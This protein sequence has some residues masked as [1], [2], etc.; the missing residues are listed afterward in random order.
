ML[1][2]QRTLNL[3]VPLSNPEHTPTANTD[4]KGKLFV[5]VFALAPAAKTNS[6]LVL[7]PDTLICTQLNSCTCTATL[8][9][10]PFKNFLKP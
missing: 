1:L 6:F 5:T 8:R 2:I 10:C 7:N 9:Q 3:F 4:N